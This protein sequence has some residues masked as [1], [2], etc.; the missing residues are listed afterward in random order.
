MGIPKSIVKQRLSQP[1]EKVE[2]STR[3]EETEEEKSVTF[4]K[5]VKVHRIAFC[6]KS[7][8]PEEIH[9]CWWSNDEMLEL[10]KRC[11][12]QVQK[13]EKGKH[14][15]DRKYCGRGLE[16]YTLSGSTHKQQNR[17]DA[18][19]RVLWEQDRQQIEGIVDDEAI[20]RVYHGV[21]A[22]VQL[23]ARVIGLKDEKEAAAYC[24]DDEESNDETSDEEWDASMAQRSPVLAPC[25]NLSAQQITIS[26]RT[27]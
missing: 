19:N 26:A 4:K 22:S 11:A 27:A 15:L 23:W 18:I 21:S 1:L 8:T 17:I 25:G 5:A 14:L 13:L 9:A 24:R 3:T 16:G 6:K 12:K 20:A 7:Y 2:S 10:T